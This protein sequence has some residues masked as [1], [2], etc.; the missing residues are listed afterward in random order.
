MATVVLQTVG[1]AVGSAA[2]G[3]VGAIV[4]R[5]AGAIA[6]N[7]IDQSL[8]SRD[9]V[10]QGPRLDQ[11]RVLT[12]GE[13]AAIPRIY[14]RNRLSGQVIWATRFE[15]VV[16]SERSGGKGGG[17]NATTTTTFSYFASV[18]IGI[19]EGPI[20]GIRR[21]WADGEELDLTRLEYRIYLGDENQ[22][23]DPLIE[24]KQGSGN[25]PAYRDTAYIVFEDLPL[26]RFGNRVPQFSFE[27]I[28]SIGTLENNIRAISVI[29]G[30][31][32]YGYD[33]EVNASGGNW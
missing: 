13:G 25:T 6:G 4:G 20:S 5:A 31:T 28:R 14:G 18:A 1:A 23:T 17:G 33:T 12:S 19:C 21:I 22:T 27:V 24:A 3:P 30:A 10:V 32:E 9:R 7:L 15:E 8:F 26:D 29:P 2:A 16:S 11:A